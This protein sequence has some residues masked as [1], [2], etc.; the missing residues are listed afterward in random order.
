MRLFFNSPNRVRHLAEQATNA[1][2]MALR[3]VTSAEAAQRLA[4]A[5]AESWA[6]TLDQKLLE[7]RDRLENQIEAAR[8]EFQRKI[9]EHWRSLVDQKLRLDVLLREVRSRMPESLE[10]DQLQAIISE[11]QN[12]LDAF[13]VSFEDRYR[14]SRA[15]IKNRQKIYLPDIERALAV[16]NGAPVVDIGCGRGEW[17]EL[18]S[19]A[20]FSAKGY[21]LNRVMVLE[22]QQRGFDATLADAFDA[23]AAMPDDSL[24]AVTGFHII[25]HLPFGKLV[26]LFD[27]ALRVLRPG[28]LVVFETPNPGNLLVASERFYMDPT[29]R[30]PLPAELIA[31]VAEARGFTSVER[32]FLHPPADRVEAPFEEPLLELLRGHVY[33]PQDYAVVGWKA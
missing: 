9:A 21:D 32:R 16:T 30:N 8:F 1:E 29:H 22:S 11:E 10:P 24:T 14:G 6:E 4:E 17:L 18:L 23:L 5:R 27:Q 12:L 3:A 13:Y 19:E 25:E 28:G 7:Q 20:G 15:D 26:Q 31:F 33:A 2:R